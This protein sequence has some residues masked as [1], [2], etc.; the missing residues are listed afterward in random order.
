MM[1]LCICTEDTGK[2]VYT[3]EKPVPKPGCLLPRSC[4][5]LQILIV[6]ELLYPTFDYPNYKLNPILDTRTMGTGNPDL[7]IIAYDVVGGVATRVICER[8]PSRA[9]FWL[10]GVQVQRAQW[11][12]WGTLRADVRRRSHGGFSFGAGQSCCGLQCNK[13]K[14]NS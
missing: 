3:E 4:H 13:D 9:A 1:R 14:G 7:R 5:L 12:A 8:L 2:T 6:M 11:R 10:P